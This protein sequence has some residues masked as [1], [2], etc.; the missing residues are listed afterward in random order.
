M[1]KRT[2]IF[3]VYSEGARLIDF[4]GWELPLDFGPG[5]IEEHLAVRKNAGLFDV[6]HMGEIIVEGPGSLD[7]LNLILT[8]DLSSMYNGRCL[9]S[10]MCYPSGTTVDDLLVY[11]LEAERFLLV[12]NAANSEKDFLWIAKEN[13]YREKFPKLRVSDLSSSYGE[14]A[15]Q[16]PRSSELLSA[17]AGRDLSK[18]AYYH[19]LDSLDLFG[20]KVLVSRTGYT[21]EDGFEIYCDAK[22]AAMVWKGLIEETASEGVIPVGLGARDTLRFEACLPL[23]G[24][25]L[26]EQI[27]P[28]EAGL[29]SFVK[30]AKTEFCGRDALIRA[31]SPR[32]LLGCELIDRGVARPGYPVV[33]GGKHAGFVTS[34]MKCPSLGSFNALILLDTEGHPAGE[35]YPAGSEVGI[36]INGSEKRAR[37]VKTPFYRRRKS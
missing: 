32:A 17:V 3:S 23:Y 18:L 29:S 11:R 27:Q 2:P 10:P 25:E 14:I 15:F 16:G 33:V 20:A 37:I 35:L 30:Y 19:F 5:I 34:G 28:A 12:V 9:Y 21:G 36:E 22:D 1:G 4:G 31:G 8:N 26:S 7:F 6:S 13:P 24:H